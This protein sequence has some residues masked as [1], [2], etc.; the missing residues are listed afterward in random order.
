LERR[1]YASLHFFFRGGME[2]VWIPL[3]QLIWF[4][5]FGAVSFIHRSWAFACGPAH[6][7]KIAVFRKELGS[8]RG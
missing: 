2:R 5:N 7:M 4:D 1:W 8:G 6:G 3:R